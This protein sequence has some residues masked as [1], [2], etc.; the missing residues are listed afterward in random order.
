MSLITG[1][2]PILAVS[3]I[4][5]RGAIKLEAKGLRRSRSPSALSIAKRRLS[6]PPTTPRAKV[7]AS[8]DT[9]IQRLSGLP[10]FSIDPDGDGWNWIHTCTQCHSRFRSA[11][12]GQLGQGRCASCNGD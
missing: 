1:T 5:L 2:N 3:F 6:L 11:F 9:T 10:E 4:A 8:L 7:L 12:Q